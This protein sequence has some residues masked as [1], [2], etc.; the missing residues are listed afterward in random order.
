MTPQEIFDTVVR[1]LFTQGKRCGERRADEDGGSFQCKYR[2]PLGTSCAV[3]VLIPDEAYDPAMEGNAVVALFDPDATSEGGFKLPDWMKE[4][5]RLLSDLQDVHDFECYWSSTKEMQERLFR[6]TLDHGLSAAVLGT[7]KFT[8]DTEDDVF[9]DAEIDEDAAGR[10]LE[11]PET[12]DCQPSNPDE[13][14]ICRGGRCRGEP[15]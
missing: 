14:P 2:G 8:W 1:H 12:P 4:N 6:V 10:G 3:G 7:L 13:C 5:V 9:S 11:P 15:S